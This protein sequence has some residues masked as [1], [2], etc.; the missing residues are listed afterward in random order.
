VTEKSGLV[1]IG[2][3]QGVCAG[4]VDNDGLVDLLITYYGYNVLYRN[5]GAGKFE[6][7]TRRT[8]LP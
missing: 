6:D 5:Q 7:I 2:W 8:G 1:N 3:G 4:D